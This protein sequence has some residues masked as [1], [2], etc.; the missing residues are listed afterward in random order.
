M[1]ESVQNGGKDMN[2]GIIKICCECNKTL[3]L[4][5][6]PTESCGDVF[7]D[8]GVDKPPGIQTARQLAHAHWV[9]VGQLLESAGVEVTPLHEHLYVEAMIHGYKHSDEDKIKMGVK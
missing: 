1:Y 5:E 8:L 6:C 2:D 4:C 9:Y 7:K 3:S